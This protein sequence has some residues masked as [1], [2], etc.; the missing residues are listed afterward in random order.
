VPLLPRQA[1]KL[2]AHQINRPM[3][4]Q[5]DQ[6]GPQRPDSWV[7]AIGTAPQLDEHVLH[8]VLRGS[9]VPE[10]TQRAAVHDRPEAVENLGQSMIVSGRQ[11]RLDAHRS[12]PRPG[13]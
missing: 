5:H 12:P 4:G 13:R 1:A 3:P 6:V 7:I 11:A 9:T 2:A 10:N 8:D